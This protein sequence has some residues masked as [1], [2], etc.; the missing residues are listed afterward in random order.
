MLPIE[1]INLTRKFKKELKLEAVK[2]Q[3][4]KLATKDAQRDNSNLAS[5]LQG[6]V[7]KLRWDYRHRHIAYCMLRGKT[8]KQCEQKCRKYN[9]PNHILIKEI[10]KA[11]TYVGTEETV[12]AAA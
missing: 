2:L 12:S 6:D 8:Y 1:Q 5:M 4:T 9:N 7:L 11:Y 10:I 3:N